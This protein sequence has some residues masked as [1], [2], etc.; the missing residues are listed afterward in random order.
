MSEP[1]IKRPRTEEASPFPV[2]S[3]IAFAGKKAPG[4]WL[5]CDGETSLDEE[6]YAN[7]KDILGS[8]DKVPDLRGSYLM[9]SEA[10]TDFLRQTGSNTISKSQIPPLT[11]D[12]PRKDYLVDSRLQNQLTALPASGVRPTETQVRLYGHTPNTNTFPTTVYWGNEIET[13]PFRPRS[14]GVNYIIK[15]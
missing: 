4:G 5:L 14:F 1:P 9:G 3:I 6:K 10:A 11:V 13:E 15:Y 8:S 7:L 2:G 12:L